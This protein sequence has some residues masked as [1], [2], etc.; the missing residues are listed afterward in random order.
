MPVTDITNLS[1]LSFSLSWVLPP[2]LSQLINQAGTTKSFQHGIWNETYFLSLV[3]TLNNEGEVHGPAVLASQHNLGEMQN[4]GSLTNLL[5]QNLRVFLNQD[6]QVIIR[7]WEALT[8]RAFPAEKGRGQGE[9]YVYLSSKT[10]FDWTNRQTL[11]YHWEKGT[12]S[13]GVRQVKVLNV[14]F[15]I[16]SIIAL[17][18]YVSQCQFNHYGAF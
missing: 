2:N 14:K 3:K 16:C 5:T 15:N 8:W 17:R 9:F 12:L 4:L 6:P 11:L 13:F 18:L 10:S 7:V 1:L